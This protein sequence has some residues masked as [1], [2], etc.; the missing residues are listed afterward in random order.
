MNIFLIKN[1]G[2]DPARIEAAMQDKS[3]AV[4]TSEGSTINMKTDSV[5]FSFPVNKEY[6]DTLMEIDVTVSALAFKAFL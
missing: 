5:A 2:L 1:A 6:P 3:N 4:I